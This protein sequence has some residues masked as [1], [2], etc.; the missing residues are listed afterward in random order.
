MPTTTLLLRALVDDV[1]FPFKGRV[2][3]KLTVGEDV[4]RSEAVR[5][6]HL[7]PLY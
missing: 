4:P 1:Q 5:A 6:N 2:T 7:V 3:L